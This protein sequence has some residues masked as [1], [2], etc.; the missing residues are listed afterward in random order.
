MTKSVK[1][2]SKRKEYEILTPCSLVLKH[3]VIAESA[4]NALKT[5]RARVR[6]YNGSNEPYAHGAKLC[7]S[8][9]PDPGE[10]GESWMIRGGNLP[11]DPTGK[12]C[13]S[14]DAEKITTKELS[15]GMTESMFFRD[16]D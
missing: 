9:W 1:P 14:W 6:A 15:K 8:S 7:F 16:K 11:N 5:L 2:R 12:T 3:K 13:H 10:K 4:E